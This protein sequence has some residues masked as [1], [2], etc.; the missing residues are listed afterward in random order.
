MLLSKR[1]S[2]PL[3]KRSSQPLGECSSEECSCGDVCKLLSRWGDVGATCLR[4]W[5]YV[6]QARRVLDQRLERLEDGD[7]RQLL[8][9]G[10]A[11]SAS[12]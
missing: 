6:L 8:L 3:C 5:G 2:Q 4:R 7:W 10:P 11:C 9:R 12:T 1:S